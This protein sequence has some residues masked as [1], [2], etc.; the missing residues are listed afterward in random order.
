ML[1]SFS[2][3]LSLLMLLGCASDSLPWQR[4]EQED[5]PAHVREVVTRLGNVI[6]AKHSATYGAWTIGFDKSNPSASYYCA[7]DTICSIRISNLRCARTSEGSIPCD[8][9][10][11]KDASCKLIIPGTQEEFNFACPYDVSLGPKKKEKAK[12]N[13][14]SP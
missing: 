13:I 9:K 14:A 8:W 4:Y 7:Q 11:T 12:G 2:V 6:D 1:R 10:L 3:L 5:F